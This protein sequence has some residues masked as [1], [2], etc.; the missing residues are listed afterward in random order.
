MTCEGFA[1][2]DGTQYANLNERELYCSEIQ[3]RLAFQG[4][5][6]ILG[7]GISEGVAAYKLSQATETTFNMYIVKLQNS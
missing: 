2:A 1:N 5:S 4:F 7:M 3:G 6:F